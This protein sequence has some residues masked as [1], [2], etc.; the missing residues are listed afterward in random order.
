M[1][2][3]IPRGGPPPRRARPRK[4]NLEA[5]LFELECF[6]QA[7][8]AGAQGPSDA[9]RSAETREM[10]RAVI[11]SRGVEQKPSE[12]LFETF[13]RALGV[14]TTV[15]RAELTQYAMGGGRPAAF[16]NASGSSYE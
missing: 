10:I 3:V 2:P 14:S 6:Y 13:A 9:E 8:I 11:A 16:Q 15:L 7:A 5:R 4:R 12:S 1:L